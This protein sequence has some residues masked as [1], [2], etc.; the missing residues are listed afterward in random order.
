VTTTSDEGEAADLAI[1]RDGDG[2]V[3]EVD[4]LK[5]VLDAGQATEVA[6]SILATMMGIPRGDVAGA[7]LG[8]LRALAGLDGPEVEA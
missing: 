7:I 1:Y 5:I 3:L 8:P 4:D 6:L 2:V